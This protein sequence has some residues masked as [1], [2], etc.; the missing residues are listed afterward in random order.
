MYYIGENETRKTSRTNLKQIA[1]KWSSIG[2]P[3]IRDILQ[4]MEMII[5]SW[6]PL[7]YKQKINA[8]R[9]STFQIYRLT[10]DKHVIPSYVYP[11]HSSNISHIIVQTCLKTLNL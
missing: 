4:I 1:G 8:N 10:I 3:I 2:L 6:L 5:M 11:K 9:S 7:T